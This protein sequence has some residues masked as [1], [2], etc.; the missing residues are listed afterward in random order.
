MK[1][2]KRNIITTAIAVIVIAM[3][4]TVALAAGA[5]RLRYIHT[6]PLASNLEYINTV[7]WHDEYGREEVYI[8][9]YTPGG[10]AF[11]IVLKD[12]TVYGAVS[13]DS[14]I[15]YA[16]QTR[17]RNLLALANADFF[18][19]QTGVPLGIFIE[20]GIYKS[21]NETANAIIFRADGTAEIIDTPTVAISLVNGSGGATVRLNHFNKFRYVAGVPYLFSSEFSTV[22]TRTTSPGWV[23]RFAIVEGS[24]TLGGQMTLEVVEMLPET[25]AVP[26]GE[27]YLILSAGGEVNDDY[28]AFAVGD[29]VTL[30]LEPS[31]PRMIEAQFA[32]GAGDVIVR[33]GS[34]TD[35]A[36]WERELTSRSPKTAVGVTADGGVVVYVVDGR[37]TTYGNG[38]RLADVAAELRA[39]GCVTAVNLDGGGSTVMAVQVPGVPIATVV[40]RPSD[41]SARRV[42]T[43][44]GFATNNVADGMAR[45][46]SLKNDGALVLSGSTIELGFVATDLAYRPV[47]APND[48]SAAVIASSGGVIEGNLYR[49]GTV[50]GADKLSL[51]SAATG[52]VGTGEVFVV[53]TPTS[54]TARGANGAEITTLRIG[55]SETAEIKP[56]ATFYRKD[57][58]VQPQ[59]F[60]YAVVGDIGTIDADGVFTASLVGGRTG[61]ITITAGETTIRVPVELKGFTDTIG[62]WGVD[63][64]NDLYEKG[65][66]SGTTATTYSPENN[67]KRGDFVLMLYRAVGQPL[68]PDLAAFTDVAEGSYYAAAIAWAKDA[69]ITTGV[70]DG[71]FAPEDMLTR[72]QAFT[73]VYRAFPSLR[74]TTT[75]E[76]PALAGFTDIADIA[77]YAKTPTAVLTAL[78][79]VGGADGRLTPRSPLTRA[80]MAK[81]LSVTLTLEG[82]T[83]ELGAQNTNDTNGGEVVA[84]G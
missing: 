37:N 10:D 9:R 12:E 65:I 23:V 78:E 29:L 22:S 75:G 28:N 48:V 77:E 79:I 45:N 60:T 41:G 17:G 24:L 39:F 27:G 66:V 61:E 5:G 50:E 6:T 13:I 73:F 55:P 3:L 67:I 8:L 57:V 25:D 62:H 16:E 56:S 68:Q 69:G 63:F 30:T 36:T 38:L 70:G 33:N 59:S 54:I 44:I 2:F 31:D 81:I 49:A 64:I 15:K 43:Y 74:I 76:A 47:T 26:I 20:D 35:E 32:A 72:E 71:R 11:P 19:T 83:V 51:S 4:V 84:V 7:N 82:K 34:V 1:K 42:A 52:A 18:S 40:N 14:A 58:A 46:L 53:T 21:S 80:Q